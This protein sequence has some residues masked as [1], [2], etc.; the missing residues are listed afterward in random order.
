MDWTKIIKTLDIQAPLHQLVVNSRI[1]PTA[2]FCATNWKGP[3]L[4]VFATVVIITGGMVALDYKTCRLGISN[5]HLFLMKHDFLFV[6]SLV[7]PFPVNAT[8]ILFSLLVDAR[9]ICVLPLG[10]ISWEI[11]PTN[12][13]TP[14]LDN[15]I[16][17][18]DTMTVVVRLNVSR[19]KACILITMM[20]CNLQHNPNWLYPVQTQKTVT[21]T[22]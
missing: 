6:C 14:K 13:R 11:K 12:G 15:Y 16:I 19:P 17:I 10:Q 2:M 1:A 18:M 5:S 7:W 3:V 4:A 9:V 21:M 22:F 20:W 8:K